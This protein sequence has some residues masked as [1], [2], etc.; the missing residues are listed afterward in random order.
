MLYFFREVEKKVPPLNFLRPKK[1]FRWP[2]SSRGE[3]G[4][5]G[6]AINGE[7]FFKNVIENIRFPRYNKII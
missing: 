3:G 2:L 4:L 6:L 1:K 7:L 5:N